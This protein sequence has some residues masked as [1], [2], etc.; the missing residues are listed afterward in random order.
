MSLRQPKEPIVGDQKMV[1]FG[2]AVCV[3]VKKKKMLSFAPKYFVEGVLGEAKQTENMLKD[4]VTDW[5]GLP[6]SVLG[7]ALKVS[8]WET[9]QPWTNWDD[10]FLYMRTRAE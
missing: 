2:A 7:L 5:S 4:E 10:G 3:Q 9:L 6:G 1:L 8:S